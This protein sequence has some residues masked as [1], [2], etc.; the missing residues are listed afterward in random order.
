MLDR[1]SIRDTLLRFLAEDTAATVSA[2]DDSTELRGALGIDSVDFVSLV[3]RIEGYYRV[4][5][6]REELE[7]LATVGDLLTLVET[8][9]AFSLASAAA[10]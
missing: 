9:T 7:G 8:K 1:T 4:R 5:L 10:A 2:I 6:S 3:M